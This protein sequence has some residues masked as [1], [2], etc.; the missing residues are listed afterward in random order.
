[1]SIDLVAHTLNDRVSRAIRAEMGARR[2]SQT[3]LG[4]MTGHSQN[5]ISRRLA[6]HMALTLDDVERI[7]Q[8]LNMPVER[9]LNAP[10]PFAPRQHRRASLCLI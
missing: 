2:L 1:M 9:L 6:G 5:G 7:A 3:W 4:K 10:D 8:A